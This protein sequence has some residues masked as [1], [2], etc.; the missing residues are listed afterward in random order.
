M[1][2]AARLSEHTSARGM[3]CDFIAHDLH[4][5]VT[6]GD[7]TE[8]QSGGE[9]SQLPEGHIGLGLRSVAGVPCR[10]DDRPGTDSVA[11]IVGAVSEG[12]S[13]GSKNL[14]KGVCVFNLVGIL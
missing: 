1:N 2:I 4:D 9:D 14:N 10:V 5:V 12:S 3:I 7:E 13:A 8:R 11:D 6:V